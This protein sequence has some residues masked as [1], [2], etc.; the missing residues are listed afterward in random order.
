MIHYFWKNNKIYIFVTEDFHILK[1][2]LGTRLIL[3]SHTGERINEVVDDLL[4][5]FPNLKEKNLHVTSDGGK[6]VQRAIK[7]HNWKS[8]VCCAHQGHLMVLVYG[9]KKTPLAWKIVT[10]VRSVTV[11]LKY[12]APRLEE[13]QLAENQKQL[14]ARLLAQFDTVLEFLNE[15][16]S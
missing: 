11:A 10:K 14:L 3:G 6:N 7:L 15:N 2:N 13:K 8:L 9:I 4:G 1:V 16:V 12:R 5:D